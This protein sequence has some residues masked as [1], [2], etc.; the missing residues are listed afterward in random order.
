MT[1]RSPRN[2]TILDGMI[3]VAAVACGFALRRAMTGDYGGVFEPLNWLGRNAR[4]PLWAVLPFLMTLT[5]AVLLIG[6]RR[7]RPVL[8]RLARQPGMAA[9]CA[10]MLPM[11]VTLAGMAQVNWLRD[12]KS[13]GDPMVWLESAFA[14]AEGGAL[15]GIW[16]LAAWLVLAIGSRR[17]AERGW[18]DRLGRLVGIGWLLVLAVYFLGDDST[19]W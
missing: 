6:L 19:W 7:P 17:R 1:P 8:R 4:E 11:T 12:P 15:T 9:C 2:F 14:V 16:V 3:L 18:I 5:P 10:A 13:A